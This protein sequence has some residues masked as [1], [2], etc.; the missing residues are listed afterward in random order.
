MSASETTAAAR[1][2]RRAHIPLGTLATIAVALVTL[3]LSAALRPASAQVAD[4][5]VR[6]TITE[7]GDSTFSFD[8]ANLR[9][10]RV[11]E[12]GMAVDPR[13]RDALVARFAVLRVENGRATAVITGE[14]TELTAE[15]LVVM[16][17]PIRPWYRSS[18][19]WGGAVMGT[20]L[21]A[22]AGSL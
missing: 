15:H 6:L 9:W 10:I 19:F 3:L 13:R 21:G 17:V 11:G 2:G 8:A 16:E 5:T 12:R 22:L 20:L 14:T 4:R 1:R 7:V 18:L